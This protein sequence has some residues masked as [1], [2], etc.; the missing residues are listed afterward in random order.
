MP[1]VSIRPQF[2][3]E[4]LDF[5][6]VSWLHQAGSLCSLSCL[7][8][9]FPSITTCLLRN[10]CQGCCGDLLGSCEGYNWN[11]RG[12]WFRGGF[13]TVLLF[14]F[15]KV[16]CV[17]STTTSPSASSSTSTT[18]F[19]ECFS[20]GLDFALA[21]W[22]SG[23]RLL[24]SNFLLFGSVPLGFSWSDSFATFLFARFVVF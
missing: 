1:E 21:D 19:A 24:C 17:V 15:L 12:T 18:P 14:L 20:Q 16:N 2:E 3:Q 22:F 7:G 9:D 23:G 13:Y 10:R 8:R 5:L 4:G 6:L 11:L